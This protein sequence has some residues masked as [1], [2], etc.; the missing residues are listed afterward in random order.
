M[1]VFAKLVGTAN[2]WLQLTDKR[3]SPVVWVICVYVNKKDAKVK[4]ENMSAP[5][6]FVNDLS[7][8]ELSADSDNDFF[9]IVKERFLDFC[10]ICNGTAMDS[11]YFEI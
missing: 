2:L 9:L 5:C 4:N 11:M 7:E 3:S 1:L 8:L 6:S 10:A